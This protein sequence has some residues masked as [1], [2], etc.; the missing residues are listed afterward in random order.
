MLLFNPLILTRG[1]K[2]LT[3]GVVLIGPISGRVWIGY[4]HGWIRFMF[5]GMTFAFLGQRPI[6]VLIKATRLD[7]LPI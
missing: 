1:Q 7:H 6:D 2:D 4:R 5:L 3:T